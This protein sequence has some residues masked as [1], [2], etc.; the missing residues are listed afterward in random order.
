MYINNNNNLINQLKIEASNSLIDQK[1]AAVLMKSSKMLTE[2]CRN[3]AKNICQGNKT[4]SIHA[5]V[6]A[7]MTYF[8][9][10]FYYDKINKRVFYSDKKNNKLNLVVIR[11]NKNGDLCNARPCYNCLNIM[12]LIG[13]KKIYYSISNDEIICEN[14]KDMISIQ[15][16]SIVRHIDNTIFSNS[17]KNNNNN[18]NIIFY[19][20]LIEKY[21]PKKI[22]FT[23]LEKFIK[24][25]LTNVLPESKI[26]ITKNK[27]IFIV[28]IINNNKILV[29]SILE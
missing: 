7:I 6:N 26:E 16:S 1:L 2:P 28:N 5:E 14:I 4:S 3:L 21:F 19:E 13:I 9:K 17:L 24:Y 23:N 10:S 20:K 12:K 25:N 8:G 27:N 11:I 15:C 29:T 22:K 18:N